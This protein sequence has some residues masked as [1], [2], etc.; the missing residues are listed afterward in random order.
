M[1][2]KVLRNSAEV[3][4]RLQSAA[5]PILRSSISLRSARL[6]TCTALRKS[7]LRQ[8]ERGKKESALREARRSSARKEATDRED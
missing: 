5:I 1:G 7:L 8:G 4:S 3:V 2:Q 6:N